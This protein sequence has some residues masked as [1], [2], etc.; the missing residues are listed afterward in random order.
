MRPHC[1]FCCQHKGWIVYGWEHTGHTA[2]VQGRPADCPGCYEVMAPCPFCED[3]RA[4]EVVA[5]G[6]RGYWHGDAPTPAQVEETCR[7]H[8]RALTGIA[9]RQRL[10]EIMQML[11][12]H[13]GSQEARKRAR[14]EQQIERA[15]VKQIVA[16]ASRT[17]QDTT[18]STNGQVEDDEIGVL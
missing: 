2:H 6:E 15:S 10:D 9:G 1:A 8:E 13:L 12:D 16:P 14:V 4:V 11:N 17:A 5:Y 3:G 7:C 18:V